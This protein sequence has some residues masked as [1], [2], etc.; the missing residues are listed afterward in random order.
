VARF[1][2]AQGAATR[3]CFRLRCDESRF[4]PL[5]PALPHASLLRRLASPHPGTVLRISAELADGI[6]IPC[7]TVDNGLTR[8]SS[9]SLM[10]PF[11]LARLGRFCGVR[12]VRGAAKPAARSAARF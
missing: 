3:R 9:G 10:R 6:E 5:Q 11:R 7:Y 1:L 4:S 8:G 12:A 2:R